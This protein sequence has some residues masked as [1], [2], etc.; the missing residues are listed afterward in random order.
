M[1]PFPF[2]RLMIIRNTLGTVAALA[3]ACLAQASTAQ[4]TTT[5]ASES[6]GDRPSWIIVTGRREGYTARD[7]A[8][9]TRTDTPLLE[10]PQ[11][12]QVL[13][14]TLI[15]ERD[16]RTLADALVNVSGVTPVR[17]EETLFTQPIVRG[18]PAEIYL[19]GLPAF[20][21]AAFIDPTSLVGVER[22]KVVKGPTSTVY[23]WGAGAPL[24]GLINIVSNGP[25]IG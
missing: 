7:A 9:A 22:V 13:T 16:R 15:E 4:T 12:V 17:Q 20:G 5:S 6:A 19:D 2:A 18:F 10:T 11:S 14:R 24:G 23:G 1:S 8:S 25:R 3:T 21:T